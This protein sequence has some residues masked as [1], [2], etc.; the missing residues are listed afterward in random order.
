MPAVDRYYTGEFAEGEDGVRFQ[1]LKAPVGAEVL[2]RNKAGRVWNLRD[3]DLQI[4]SKD[5][6]TGVGWRPDRVALGPGRH[7]FDYRGFLHDVLGTTL[8]EVGVGFR[9]GRR[10]GLRFDR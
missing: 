8:L 7:R 1:V 6:T 9:H 5:V 2:G 10:R 3:G 4:I